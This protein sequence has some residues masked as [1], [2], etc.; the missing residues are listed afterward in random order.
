MII[1]TYEDRILSWIKKK[2]WFFTLAIWSGFLLILIF[3]SDLAGLFPSKAVSF[4]L[5]FF[6]ELFFL[7]GVLSICLKFT[8]NNKVLAYLGK[9]SLEIYLV[10][11]LFIMGLRSGVIFIQNETLW[12]FLTI[13][14]S[15]V[16]GSLLHYLLGYILRLFRRHLS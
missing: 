7:L 1:A 11:G 6:L 12:A 8:I 13:I 3:D 4:A 2:Y 16:F 9:I 14:G 5:T 10:H 15:I